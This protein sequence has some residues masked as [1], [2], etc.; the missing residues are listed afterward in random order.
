MSFITTRLIG[1]FEDRTNVARLG[2]RGTSRMA[3]SG[4]FDQDG[5]LDLY[6]VNDGQAKVLYL[7]QGDGT[8]EAAPESAGL[9]D[10]SGG[11]SAVAGDFDQDGDLDIYLVKDREANVLYLNQG[12]GTFTVAPPEASVADEDRSWGVVAAD[13][14]HDSDLDLYVTNLAQANTLYLS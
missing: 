14:D 10:R 7:N 3:V 9:T 6:V 5:D 2:N 13:F 8:F 1:T 12:D 11:R 4:D